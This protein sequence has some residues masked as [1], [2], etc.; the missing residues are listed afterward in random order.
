MEVPL[1]M[2]MAAQGLRPV[3]RGAEHAASLLRQSLHRRSR[4][5]HSSARRLFGDTMHSSASD[6]RDGAQQIP[7]GGLAMKSPGDRSNSAS[8][9]GRYPGHRFGDPGKRLLCHWRQCLRR[10]RKELGGGHPDQRQKM[11]SGFVFVFGLGR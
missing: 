9:L 8:Q 5:N 11:L 7:R 10:Y 1:H 3:M 4:C 6:R 2:V